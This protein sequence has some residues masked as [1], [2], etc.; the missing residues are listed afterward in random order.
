[1]P[2]QAA[3]ARPSPADEARAYLAG[4]KVVDA[5]THISEW[6]D[7]WTSRATPKYK[8]RVPQVRTIDGKRVW[9]IDDHVISG[10]SGFAAIKKD[11]TK[12]PGI[13]FFDLKLTDV[14]PGAYDLKARLDYLDQEGIAAQ[15]AYTNLLGFGGPKAMKVDAE[16]RTVS[17]KIQN[18]AM[19]E[20]QAAS[21]NRVYPMAMLPWWDIKAA[22]AEAERC[23]GMGLRGLNTHASPEEH[24]VPDLNTSHWTP[25]WELAEARN[26]PIN[27]HI[28]FS[29]GQDKENADGWVKPGVWPSFTGYERYASAGTLLF[30]PNM[31][32][33]VNLLLSDIFRRHPRLKFV[34]VESGVGWVPYMLEKLA[35]QISENLGHIEEPVIETFRKHIYACGWAE[36]AGLIEYVRRIGAE[37][38]L[39]ETD[40]PHPTCLYPGPLEYHATTLAQLEPDARAKVFGGNAAALYNL[41]LSA[42]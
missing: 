29:Q 19:A 14:H 21:N 28:G 15:I 39:F 10:D 36:R 35:Y 5:D 37:N 26:L 40:F 31:Q 2:S 23:A 38:L 1:M 16:L 3:E 25:L 13:D 42:A 7:L 20:L 18:D 9:T 30:A 22:V 6:P 33:I 32:V 41:D 17:I 27:F 24:G 12:A 34:S 4:V 11:G 8:D